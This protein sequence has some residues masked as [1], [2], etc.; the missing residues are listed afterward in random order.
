MKHRFFF[1][2]FGLLSASTNSF[3]QQQLLLLNSDGT[4]SNYSLA[5]ADEFNTDQLDRNK[6]M[7]SYPWGR[8][9]TGS[10]SDQETLEYYT[11]GKNSPQ[12]EGMISLIAKKERTCGNCVSWEDSSKLNRNGELNYRCF[13]YSSGMIYSKEPYGYGYYEIR[14]KQAENS[15]GLWP[16]FWL[17]GHD[18]EI[19]IFENK[20]ERI[21]E[22]HWDLHCKGGCNKKYGG[23]KKLNT[24]FTKS[25]NTISFEWEPDKQKWFCNGINYASKG[26]LYAEGMHIIANNAVSRDRKNKGFW[27]GTDATTV[28]P[29]AL[30][31]DYIRYFKT[32]YTG[33]K[34]KYYVED[35]EL[36]KQLTTSNKTAFTNSS[37]KSKSSRLLAIYID[38]K[39]HQLICD[40]N[41]NQ[42]KQAV[43]SVYNSNGQLIKRQPLNQKNQIINQLPDETFIIIARVGK[44]IMA[45]R[46][47][48]NR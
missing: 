20:G 12:K 11:D 2:L 24:D 7:T 21:N 14:F 42:K 8:H 45:E 5:F 28:F 25:F 1:L 29:S 13:D 38:G 46:V 9:L 44:K 23:W 22:T 27:V 47:E 17:F 33:R 36:L 32:H 16:A 15:K 10:T 35:S 18:D 39:N 19:D 40:F 48:V 3:C 30:D 37:V 34:W 6:W 41:G 43:V 4:Q 26:Q 31:I